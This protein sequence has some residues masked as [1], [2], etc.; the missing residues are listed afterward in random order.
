[1]V[2]TTRYQRARTRRRTAAPFLWLSCIAALNI[3]MAPATTAAETQDQET[4]LARDLQLVDQTPQLRLGAAAFQLKLQITNPRP[5][6]SIYV[7]VFSPVASQV[8][9]GDIVAG[10]PLSAAMDS[11]VTVKIDRAAQLGATTAISIPLQLDGDIRRKET[12]RVPEAGIYPL[13]ISLQ[14][15]A[16]ISDDDPKVRSWLNVYDP[17][18][19]PRPVSVAQIWRIPPTDFTTASA[20]RNSLRFLNNNTKT[21]RTITAP[22]TVSIDASTLTSWRNATKTVPDQQAFERFLSDVQ[23]PNRSVLTASYATIDPRHYSAPTMSG[24]YAEELDTGIALLNEQPELATDPRTYFV[25]SATYQSLSE[26]VARGITSVVISDAILQN[27]DT[28]LQFQRFGIDSTKLRAISTSRPAE[29]HLFKAPGTPTQRAQQF[30]AWLA[31]LSQDHPNST[32]M[33]DIPRDAM[34]DP[35]AINALQR[36]IS[37]RNPFAE[38]VTATNALRQSPP[39]TDGQGRPLIRALADQPPPPTLVDL[40]RATALRTQLSGFTQLTG[41]NEDSQIAK[42]AFLD[43]LA[44]NN[45]QAQVTHYLNRVQAVVDSLNSTVTVNSQTIT[46]TSQRSEVPVTFTNNSGRPLRVRVSLTSPRIKQ[47]RPEEILDL[48]ASPRNQTHLIQLDVKGSGEFP[49]EIA[50]ISPDGSLVVGTSRITMNS[51][52]FGAFGSWLTYGAIAF[53]AVWWLHHG[54]RKRVA[55]RA[56]QGASTHA[57]NEVATVEPTAASTTQ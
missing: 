19:L 23:R 37:D 6:D 18:D 35:K 54:W 29:A 51:T 10:R 1:M 9:F 42:R 33:L 34:N 55:K 56:K 14:S 52:V 5:N 8:A 53:L 26:L 32:I 50:V 31:L 43:A 21:L 45:S 39:G 47:T 44:I 46:L 13:R 41:T 2:H 11:P 28:S 15:R 38:T 40:Q 17:T 3:V 24:V 25:E 16:Q 22:V 27:L 57:G 7:E 20:T 36:I 4:E 48:P 49:V 30:G 12:L